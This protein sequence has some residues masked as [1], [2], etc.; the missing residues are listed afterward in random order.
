[1]FA[2][3]RTVRSPEVIIVRVVTANNYLNFFMLE[4][5]MTTGL[6]LQNMRRSQILLCEWGSVLQ[7][8]G[9]PWN[10]YLPF[11]CMNYIMCD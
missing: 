7:K 11:L 6:D 1:M 10:Q 4:S 8:Y 3:S 5:R 2:K 9:N